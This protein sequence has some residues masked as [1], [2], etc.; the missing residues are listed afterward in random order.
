MNTSSLEHALET[1]VGNKIPWFVVAADEAVEAVLL[2]KFPIIVIQNT[3]K[4]SHE[5][6][7]WICWFILSHT[8]AEVMDSF[9]LAIRN[10]PE[11]LPPVKLVVKENCRQLQ[12][13]K[14][15]YCGLWCLRFAYERSLGHSFE[16]FISLFS[17][18]KL[19]NEWKLLH[20]TFKH[21]PMF[22]PDKKYKKNREN[23][24]M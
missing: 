3:R 10:Y 15:N 16:H 21:L 13:D 22:K 7:H 19:Y 5:G 18:N 20:W 4:R 14:S 1:L 12:S 2:K 24:K 9:G 8:C 6:E 23:P 11:V 17:S